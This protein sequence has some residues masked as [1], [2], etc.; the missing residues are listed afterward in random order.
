MTNRP[1]HL[2]SD[3]EAIVVEQR[4]WV[5]LSR[6]CKPTWLIA[7]LVRPILFFGLVPYRDFWKGSRMY[8]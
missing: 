4:Q 2:S 5:W 7:E 8:R 6:L 3:Y 1:T